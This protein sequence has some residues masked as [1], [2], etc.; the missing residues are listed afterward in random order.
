ML[1]ARRSARTSSIVNEDP[2]ATRERVEALTRNEVGV[3]ECPVPGIPLR[4]VAE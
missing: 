2:E 4:Q 1:A 3:Q